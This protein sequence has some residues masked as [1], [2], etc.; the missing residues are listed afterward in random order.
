MVLISDAR[1]LS[2]EASAAQ[3]LLFKASELLQLK[4]YLL[5][6]M[7]LSDE[8]SL[9]EEMSQL[10]LSSPPILS[11]LHKHQFLTISILHSCAQQLLSQYPSKASSILE[12]TSIL[13]KSTVFPALSLQNANLKAE[14]L[15]S[16]QK[17]SQAMAV[18]KPEIIGFD[19]Q[20]VVDC[21]LRMQYAQLHFTYGQAILMDVILCWPHLSS[22]IWEGVGG[23]GGGQDEEEDEEEVIAPKRAQR[24]TRRLNLSS[25][26]DETESKAKGRGKRKGKGKRT[27][28]KPEPKQ[29]TT[30]ITSSSLP[31]FLYPVISNL[32]TSYQLCHPSCCFVLLREVS[33]LLTVC[34]ASWDHLTASHFLLHSSHLTLTH[35]TIL[36]LGRKIRNSLTVSLPSLVLSSLMNDSISSNVHS[37]ELAHTLQARNTLLLST[38]CAPNLSCTQRLIDSLPSDWTFCQVVLVRNFF[39]SNLRCLVM[40]RVRSGKQ[41]VIV[42]IPLKLPEKVFATHYVFCASR[43]HVLTCINYFFYQFR[44]LLTLYRPRTCCLNLIL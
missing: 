1:R 29:K 6:F 19:S 28:P 11:S 14:L 40:V 43:A 10:T 5:S 42:R 16:Q 34:L 37:V 12:H 44:M 21:L 33:Q 36:N 3:S 39:D 32:L 31:S 18:C 2:G 9:V 30:S 23:L 20:L 27:K 26:G 17:P 13:L 15:L 22:C 41:P 38:P 4:S 8:D 35:Q 24:C 25:D 7:P